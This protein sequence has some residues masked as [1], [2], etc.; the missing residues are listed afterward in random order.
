[1]NESPETLETLEKE[2]IKK[3]M[4]QVNFN[5]SQAARILGIARKTLREKMQRYGM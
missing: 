1:M 4:Q 2:Y 5:K 3:V